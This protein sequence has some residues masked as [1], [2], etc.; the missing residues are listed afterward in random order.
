MMQLVGNG[1][2]WRQEEEDQTI[3]QQWLKL[4]LWSNVSVVPPKMSVQDGF[5]QKQTMA[6]VT[7]ELVMWHN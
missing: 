3:L 2:K 1:M 4:Q 5:S 6:A 7:C